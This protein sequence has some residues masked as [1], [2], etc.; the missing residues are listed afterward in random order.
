MRKQFE[1]KADNEENNYTYIDRII[2]IRQNSNK[3]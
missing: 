3:G 2:R 1:S